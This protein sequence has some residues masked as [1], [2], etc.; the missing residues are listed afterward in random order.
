M[1]D[2]IDATRQ[3]IVFAK[4]GEVFANSRDV[5]DYFGKQHRNVLEAIDNLIANEPELGLRNFRQTP[6]VEPSTGQTYRSFDMDRRAFSVLA[7]G[8]TGAKAL[9]W[10]LRYIDAFDAMEAELRN[11]PASINVRDPSQLATIAIQLIEVNKELE[12]RAQSAEA[13]VVAAK[14]KTLFYDQFVNTDGLYSL[15]N[16]ARVLKQ[17]PNKFV[18]WLKQGYLFYQGGALVPKVQWREAGYFEVKATIVDDKARYQTFVTP[19]GIQY[20]SK[21]LRSDELPLMGVA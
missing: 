13:A 20:F 7:M 6:Y 17:G 10:K 11:R 8:F 18:G 14:P 15:Q 4:D 5:G 9:K 19:K 16:A 12:T 1:N 21:K 3:P 2:M